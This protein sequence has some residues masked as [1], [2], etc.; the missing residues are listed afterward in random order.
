[1]MLFEQYFL[2]ILLEY[3]NLS[4][5]IDMIVYEDNLND[6]DVV[7]LLNT[8]DSINEP[9]MRLDINRDEDIARGNLKLLQSTTSNILVSFLNVM[10][11]HKKLVNINYEKV[12]DTVFKTRESEKDMFTDRLK[13]MTEE[14][15]QADTILKINKLGVWNKGLQKGLT[16][17]VTENYDEEQHQREKLT[18]IENSLLGNVNVNDQNMEQYIDDIMEQ[19]STAELIEREE[20][21][22]SHLTE[23]Y[24][25][26]DYQ[27]QEEDDWEDYN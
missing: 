4:S 9:I 7:G 20:Y 5:N 12:M 26:G 18:S 19:Q 21:D 15:R 14:A 8:V 25:D 23:D 1:M 13:G 24:D 17:Y 27:G 3:V 11:K 6:N 16:T 10:S 22:M 2:I